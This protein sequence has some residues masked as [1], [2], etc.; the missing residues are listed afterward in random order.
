MDRKAP[1]GALTTILINTHDPQVTQVKHK[2]KKHNENHTK[3]IPFSTGDVIG[4][5][6]G[7]K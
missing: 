6:N 4:E 3:N 2:N 5:G 1:N 7:V